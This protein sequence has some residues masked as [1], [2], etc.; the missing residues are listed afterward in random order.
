MATVHADPHVASSEHLAQARRLHECLHALNKRG[1]ERRLQ[2]LATHMIEK[3]LVRSRGDA[4]APL[5]HLDLEELRTA[6]SRLLSQDDD[7]YGHGHGHAESED[8]AC[9]GGI[10]PNSPPG[11]GLS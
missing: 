6:L 2:P 8:H 7:G 11:S 9:R 4:G 1:C 10:G 3:R 5:R